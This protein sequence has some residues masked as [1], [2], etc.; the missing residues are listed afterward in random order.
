MFSTAWL[1]Q[2]TV[3]S[4]KSESVV[5]GIDSV[6]STSEEV[7]C[8]RGTVSSRMVA[9]VQTATVAKRKTSKAIMQYHP[10]KM[11]RCDSIVLVKMS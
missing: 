4:K 7:S 6:R 11:F 5:T 10:K 1:S 3:R 8:V 9:L 2:V